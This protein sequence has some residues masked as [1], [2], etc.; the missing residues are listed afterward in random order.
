M[1][2]PAAGRGL[3]LPHLLLAIAVVAV[4]GSNFVVAHVGLDQ[5]PPFTF[6]ALRF[7]LVSLPLLPFVK[8]PQTSVTTI[9]AYGVLIGVGQ[10]GLMFY[11]MT[12]PISPGLAS[13][14]IQTQ[15]FF[16]IGL[17]MFFSR[18]RPQTANLIA[19][20]V[21]FAGIAIIGA[22]VGGDADLMGIVLVLGAAMSWA[23]GN[24]VVKRAGQIDMFALV[25]WSGLFAVPPLALMAV[26][27]EGPSAMTGAMAHADWIGWSTVLWQTIGNSLFGYVA[28]NWLLSRHPATQVAPMGLLVPVFGLSAAAW[29]LGEPLPGWKL[30]AAG[31]VIAGLIINLRARPKQAKA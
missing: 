1:T 14:L 13:L 18:E 17:A 19:L 26:V 6:A 29:F 12:G 24:I 4:W 5:F 25:V 9:A 11:A 27:L 15:T 16:T 10:F 30:A 3:P 31:L 22:H 20:A 8:R 2:A 23:G 7:A 28:W 21:S